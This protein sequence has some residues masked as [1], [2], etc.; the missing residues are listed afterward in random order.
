MGSGSAAG[1]PY[2]TRKGNAIR[3]TTG[4]GIKP[5]FSQ[6]RQPSQPTPATPALKGSQ[7]APPRPPRTKGVCLHQWGSGKEHPCANPQSRLL[8]PMALAPQDYLYTATSHGGR[9]PPSRSQP[10]PEPA[11]I[12]ANYREHSSTRQGAQPSA[13]DRPKSPSTKPNPSQEA[14][15]PRLA[16]MLDPSPSRVDPNLGELQRAF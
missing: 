5:H 3:F 16:Q 15:Y 9:N 12:A 4:N 10:K 2:C 13:G 6:S 8:H 14:L 1:C 7:A 11:D